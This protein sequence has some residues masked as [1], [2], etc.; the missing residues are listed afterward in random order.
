MKAA[1]A[2][3]ELETNTGTKVGPCLY[4]EIMEFNFLCKYLL[5]HLGNYSEEISV[6]YEY[7]KSHEYHEYLSESIKLFIIVSILGM[8]LAKFTNIDGIY[9]ILDNLCENF[10]SFLD[11]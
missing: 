9:F 8:Q 6:A 5:V 11:N 1:P 10:L 7:H 4:S 2:S 3:Q